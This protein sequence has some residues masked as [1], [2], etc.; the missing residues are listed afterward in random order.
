MEKRSS[1]R[2]VRGGAGFTLVELLVVLSIIGILVSLMLNGVQAVRE[3]AR[4]T[5]C[6]NN[7]RQHALA[8]HQFHATFRSLPLGNDTT[9]FR[10]QA[11]STAILPQLE[12]AGIADQWNRKVAWDDAARNLE[13]SK[14]VIPTFR[15][16]TSL[17]DEPGDTDYA[18]VMGSWL[19]SERSVRASGLNNGVLITSGPLRSHPVRLP[20]I[21]DGTSQTIFIAEVTDR[22]PEEHGLWADGRNVISHDN[23]GVN[24]NN[25]GEIYSFHPGGAQISFSDGSTNFL[26]ESVEK[27][28]IG[29]LCSRNGHE[30]I[31]GVFD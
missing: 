3:A 22:L 19:G 27:T 21:F 8:L 31:E 13:L 26:T 4:R 12:Q 2:T 7:L 14:R 15:C 20:E 10:D 23:G 29:A 5:S 16:P 6:S 30:P 1:I 25:T 24:V 11:W 17:I 18:G 28:L 9:E